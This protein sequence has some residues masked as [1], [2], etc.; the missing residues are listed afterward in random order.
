MAAAFWRSRSA[1]SARPNSDA[2]DKLDVIIPMSMGA[3]PG[4]LRVRA[5]SVAGAGR[6]PH[7]GA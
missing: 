7:H 1:S 5:N 2:A 3:L 6:P 4:L